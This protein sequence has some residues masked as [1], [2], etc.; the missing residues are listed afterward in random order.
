M[1]VLSPDQVRAMRLYGQYLHP[2]DIQ[3]NLLDVVR[4][5][6]GVNAQFTPAMHLSLRARV[7]GLT[8]AGIED[9]IETQRTLMRTWA[10]RGTIH[11]LTTQDYAWLHPLLSP[12]S[13]VKTKGRL[14]E[15][16]LTES[17]LT[18][19]IDLIQA[20][21]KHS[22]PLT[23]EELAGKLQERGLAI[24]WEGQTL[25][26][27]IRHA[28]LLGLLCIGPVRQDRAF[29]YTLVKEWLGPMRPLL[30]K[31]AL[32]EIVYRYLKGYGPAT[33]ADMAKWSGL[34][35]TQAKEGWKIF[36]E[37]EP[38]K[39]AIVEDRTLWMLDDQP[40]PKLSTSNPTVNLLPAFDT[41]L[42]GYADRDFLI[43]PKFQK[44]VYHGGQ[45]VPVIL[46]NGIAVGVWRYERKGKHLKIIINAIE[47]L[48]EPVKIGIAEEVADISRFLGHPT[49]IIYSK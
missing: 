30:E 14:Q 23:R 9:S 27:L 21:L 44:H 28:A 39:N 32:A 36:Q 37:R 29:T 7:P 34:S 33:P 3:R 26:H 43:P 10:M 45:V 42:L 12:S 31:D 24:E 47:T 6:C 35:V 22:P 49:S 15:L 1:D 2:R 41:L 48:E 17:T 5:V 40:V 20:V 16:G 19:G 8:L 11:L 13:I 25:I 38:L 18:R 4:S 46:V